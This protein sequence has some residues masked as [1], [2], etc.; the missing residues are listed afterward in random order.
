[1]LDQYK[2]N[3]V[4]FVIFWVK[5]A[6]FLALQEIWNVPPNCNFTANG[7]HP[8]VYKIRDNSGLNPNA[9]G[10]GLIISA[11]YE[12]EILDKTSTFRPHTFESIFAKI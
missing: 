7:Y 5:I 8:L 4:I 3:G 1:M 9:G 10:V 12:Y 11:K 2:I 6:K